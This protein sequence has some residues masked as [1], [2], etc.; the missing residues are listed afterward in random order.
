MAINPEEIDVT[1]VDKLDDL[2]LAL[3][4]FFAHTNLN[5]KLGKSDFAKLAEFLAPYITA[6]G[7]SGFLATTGTVLPAASAG[8]FTIVS[9][10]TTFTQ[11]T[12][13]NVV[14]TELFNILGSSATTWSL[15]KAIPL[16]NT[17]AQKSD[18]QY[19]GT[20]DSIA[21]AITGVPLAQRKL[22][23]TV[24]IKENGS[25]VEYWWR[26]SVAEGGLV[27]KTVDVEYKKIDISSY[28]R[29]DMSLS[30]AGAEV[31][32]TGSGYSTVSRLPVLGSKKYVIENIT[33]ITNSKYI[34][35]F[36]ASGILISGSVKSLT[37]SIYAFES[38]P[39]TRFISF[40]FKAP[41]ETSSLSTIK[42]DSANV[43]KI[44]GKEIEG[45][46]PPTVQLT[47]GITA[48]YLDAD[49]YVVFGKAITSPG[50]IVDGAGYAIVFKLPVQ[51][52]SEY[53][54]SDMAAIANAKFL[55]EHD[56]AGN[57]ITGAAIQLNTLPFTFKTS[58]TTKFI[59]FT[60]KAPAEANNDSITNLKVKWAYSATNAEKT[61]QTINGA[62][63]A[64]AFLRAK[65]DGLFLKKIN[66]FPYKEPSIAL[67]SFGA[68]TSGVGYTS[69]IRI[70]TTG[71]EYEI[72]GIVPSTGN[73]K[74][75]VEYNAGGT[76]IKTTELLTIPYRFKKLADTKRI[77]FTVKA[78]SE[79]NDDSLTNA[80]L[81][82][83]SGSIPVYT[84][85]K[86]TDK[87]GISFGDS[88]TWYDGKTF[89]TTHI[90]SGQ[91]V[92]GYQTYLK[93][94]LGCYISNQG[95]SGW[96]M[97]QIQTVIKAADF[98]TTDFTTITSGANDHRKGVLPGV[99]GAI[100]GT[101]NLATYAGA[102]QSSIEYIINQNNKCKIYLITPINGWYNQSGT[103]EVPGPYKGEMNISREYVD[104]VI[105]LGKLYSI[106]VCNWYD[107]VFIN[108]L[109]RPTY[110]GDKPETAYYLHPTQE[111]F[112]LMGEYLTEFLR[113]N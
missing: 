50:A 79:S 103:S 24:G 93:D 48:N 105:G 81:V 66:L 51:S 13:G 113:V 42:E 14:T 39:S 102:M 92:I 61:V 99:V 109:N 101:F 4:N 63:L 26:E 33:P 1:T 108:K 75:V 111:G 64:D 5:G 74:Q 16:P 67:T 34:A 35:E 78:A 112:K 91:R 104:V 23:D 77:S 70:P 68:E 15:V 31:N 56:S 55:I 32:T 46:I 86:W 40:T 96:D 44:N 22:G 85:S 90:E 89:S 30:S 37:T 83:V 76:A 71:T 88:I 28:I 87:K 69:A 95:Q 27:K 82:E 12:G 45:I 49:N 60:V 21:L 6:I 106:P 29:V 41:S 7:G 52:S 80:Y 20:F 54:I 72:G 8:K 100:G 17:I 62:P 18:L 3:G 38:T 9:G 11:A 110:I 107:N 98:T 58:S 97:T 43:S 47:S 53:Q 57:K 36:D 25:I 94:R 19:K 59:T 73:S 65:V 2:N 84:I 10:P